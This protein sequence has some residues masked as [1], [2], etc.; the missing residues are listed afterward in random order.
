[1]K[2]FDPPVTHREHSPRS[3]QDL[4]V[5]FPFPIDSSSPEPSSALRFFLQATHQNNAQGLRAHA[6]QIQ[7]E[8]Y[9]T[10]PYPC[11][12]R[13]AFL[14]YVELELELT[15]P[16]SSY[17]PCNMQA[18]SRDISRLLASPINWSR[19]SSSSLRR[20]RL[21]CRHGYPEACC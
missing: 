20:P 1:M 6:E 14:S 8:A 15:P 19:G 18:Q 12:R 11:I 16:Q 10:W 21:F 17:T 5:P 7:K 9:A 2:A 13:W 3:I 4:N